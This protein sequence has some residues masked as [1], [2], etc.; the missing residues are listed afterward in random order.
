MRAKEFEVFLLKLLVTLPLI[1]S[2]HY[3]HLVH[4]LLKHWHL[5]RVVMADGRH[6]S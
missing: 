6:L 5:S 2:L 3:L 4:I 1:Q